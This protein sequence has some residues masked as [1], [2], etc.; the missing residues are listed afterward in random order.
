MTPRT[1][2][3]ELSIAPLQ[4]LMHSHQIC[5]AMI[6]EIAVACAIG[7][8][9]LRWCRH[10]RM[11]VRSQVGDDARCMAPEHVQQPRAGVCTDTWS[12]VHT[13]TTCMHAIISYV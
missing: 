2:Q 1:A 9:V 6:A 12:A 3:D 7:A 8:G 10:C 5:P 11:R 13:A 4:V